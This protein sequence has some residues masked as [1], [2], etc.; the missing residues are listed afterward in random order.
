MSIARRSLSFSGTL[1]RLL[2]ATSLAASSS[3]LTFPATAQ[4]AVDPPWRVGRLAQITGSVST[5][6]AG[7]T[8]WADAVLNVPLTSGDAVWTQPQASAAIQIADNQIAL[9]ASTELDLATLDNH[10]FIATEPQGELFLD[11]RDVPSGD[12][13]TITTPR[14][15]VQ[16]GGAGQYGIIAGDSASPTSISVISGSARI[17]SG[18]FSLAVGPNQ[19]ALITGSDTLQGSVGPLVR[20]DFLASR[21]RQPAPRQVGPAAVRY[22]TGG[23]SLAQYGNWQPNPQYGQ[24]W[25]PQVQSG[26]A[27]YREG[28]WSYVEPWG[29]TWVDNEPWGFA[30]FHYGRWS[31]FNGRWGWVPGEQQDQRGVYEQ[32]TYA[33]ALVDFV[34][35]GAVGAAVGGLLAGGFGH[36]RGDRGDRGGGGD[37]GW[38]PLGPGEAYRPTFNANQAYLRQ[39]NNGRIDNTRIDNRRVNNTTVINNYANRSALTVIPAAAMARSEPVGRV[40]RT[41]PEALGQ[42]GGGRPGSAQAGHAAPEF[43]PVRGAFP[44]RP[45]AETRGV[46]PAVA[47]RLGLPAGATPRTAAPGPAINQAL[48]QP[49]AL[50][51]NRAPFRGGAAPAEAHPAGAPPG[52]PA[53]AAPVAARD[54]GHPAQAA[55]AP[56]ARPGLPALRAPGAVPAGVPGSHPGETR[57]AGAPAGEPH[58]EAGR[59]GPAAAASTPP[60]ARP[61]EPQGAPGHPE[62]GHPEPGHP[63]PGHPA[64]GNTGARP[65]E[66]AHAQPGSGRDSPHQE[67]PHPAPSR[68]EAQHEVAPHAGTPH[69][70]APR[71]E[72]PRAAP[73]AP[74][75]QPVHEAPRPEPARPAPRPAEPHPAPRPAAAPHPAPAPAPHPGPQPHKDDRPH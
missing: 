39:V 74:R 56:G 51:A 48:F 61:P 37:I 31:Q 42:A 59:P 70:Q 18:S 41:G 43:Q 9:S 22:M 2:A 11:L 35:A 60:G 55:E 40:A 63:E 14:G 71:Q 21:M 65:P 67:A 4:D 25:Y 10:Q 72:A 62:P 7:A 66:Q 64:P 52:A 20:D 19:T 49:H 15:G 13:Y 23:E 58:P 69:Q 1:A 32:P 24:V 17:V 47:Q 5:H 57:P 33:P 12:S 16:L 30:P 29:W 75:A 54:A 8:D 28:S 68:P 26:W 6:G 36:D 44:V 73:P 27:P 34:V 50:P 38:I 53:G 3:G 45:A 46:T